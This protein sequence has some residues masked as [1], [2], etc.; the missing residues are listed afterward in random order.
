MTISTRSLLVVVLRIEKQRPSH[1][2]RSDAPT[3]HV[4]YDAVQIGYS[5]ACIRVCLFPTSG[6]RFM[7]HGSNFPCRSLVFIGIAHL[8]MMIRDAEQRRAAWCLAGRRRRIKIMGD[9]STAGSI[10]RR[11]NNHCAPGPPL[12][13][14]FSYVVQ[15]VL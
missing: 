2:K 11:S 15:L 5:T 14:S 7:H 4:L 10:K 3:M 9:P 6:G 12:L 13:I 8:M 1:R